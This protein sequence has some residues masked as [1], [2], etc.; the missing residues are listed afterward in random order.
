MFEQPRSTKSRRKLK[1]GIHE[2]LARIGKAVSSPV[3]FEILELLAQSER[4]VEAIADE[5][6]QS[7][8][9]TSHHLQ[10]LRSARLV[11]ARKDGLFVF[12]R[13]A[14]PRV[15]TLCQR[16]RELAEQ[17]FEELGQLV[18][19][20]LG[21]RDQ[22]EPITRTELDERLRNGTVLVVDVR[23][24]VEYR[25]GH[26][27]GAISV[28]VAELASRLAG[29]PE[30]VEIVAYCRGPYCVYAHEAVQLLRSRGRTARRLV[31]G[32]PE[33]RAVGLP[34]ETVEGLSR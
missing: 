9:N 20:Y 31:D 29:L 28:P 5:L 7:M 19:N 15:F 26:I 4:P 32:F 1:T 14:D 18:S 16:I 33:W 34:I 24:E 11:D 8:A 22:L 25:A 6:N 17:Q 10:A 3:R 30:R 12:Y 2:Q 23:P 27:A 21:A 13:L